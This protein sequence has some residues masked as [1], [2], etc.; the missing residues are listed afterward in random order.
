MAGRMAGT[1]QSLEDSPMR[2]NAPQGVLPYFGYISVPHTPT[3]PGERKTVLD[4][5]I[6]VT[7]FRILCQWN[8]DSRLQLLVECRIP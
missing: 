1:Y 6:P 8:L 3:P 5:P 4:Y 7:G 2:E